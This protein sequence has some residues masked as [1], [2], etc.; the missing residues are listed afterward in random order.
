MSY[1]IFT[2]STNI[3]FFYAGVCSH[4]RSVEYF[5]ESLNV[6][7]ISTQCTFYNVFKLG[8][9]ANNFK[10]FMGQPVSTS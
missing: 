10:T 2:S 6:P 7:F 8:L 4:R 5:I 1:F 9:C 3:V